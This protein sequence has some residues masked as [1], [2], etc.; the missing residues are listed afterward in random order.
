[1]RFMMI[2]IPKGY[3]K[4]KPGTMP[5]A[6]MVAAM[7]KY[8]L[9]LKNAGVLLSVD[10]LHPQAEGVRVS[11]PNGQPKITKWP[12]PEANETVGGYWLI[13]VPSQ[14]EAIKWATKVPPSDIMAIEIRQVQEI[15][16]FPED[17]KKAAAE[18]SLSK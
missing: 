13:N 10:G 3:E 5:D 14:E 2:V 16:D 18:F 1:M 12:F 4:A 15:E 7:S 9:E 8:N 17:V 11:F 6:K